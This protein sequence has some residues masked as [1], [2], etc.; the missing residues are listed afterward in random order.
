MSKLTDHAKR[1]LEHIGAFTKDSDFYEGMTGNAVM[2]LIEVFDKQGHSG[3]SA[4]IVLR[5][6]NK[7]ADFKPISPLTFDDSEWHTRTRFDKDDDTYQNERDSAVFKEGKTGRPHYI[8]AHLQRDP[9]G[10]CWGGTL[11]T[12]EGIIGRCYI[13]DPKHCPTVYIDVDKDGN[14]LNPEQLDELKKYYDVEFRKGDKK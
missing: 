12:P 3:M 14:M 2:E 7:L 6:F 13:K 5:L 9:D 10:T 4:N 1:E 8:L 11:Q